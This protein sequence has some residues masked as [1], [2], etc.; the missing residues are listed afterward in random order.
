MSSW[1]HRSAYN[2]ITMTSL[3]L[4]WSLLIIIVCYV[5]LMETLWRHHF[6]YNVRILI[7]TSSL[8]VCRRRRIRRSWRNNAESYR[9][10]IAFWTKKWKSWRNWDNWRCPNL[11]NNK[12]EWTFSFDCHSC[13]RWFIYCPVEGLCVAPYGAPFHKGAPRPKPRG[14]FMARTGPLCGSIKSP[15][16]FVSWLLT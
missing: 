14:L 12:R 10:K 4:Y 11:P 15:F 5:I 13:V 6:I 8:P 3:L 1:R 2:D 7:M 16:W 9:I